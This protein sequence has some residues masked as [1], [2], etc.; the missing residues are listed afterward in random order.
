VGGRASVELARLA[1]RGGDRH[2]ARAL[3]ERAESLCAQGSDRACIDD[4]RRLSRSA[5][6]R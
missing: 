1:M 2:A 3:A 6:G 4:A 5:R